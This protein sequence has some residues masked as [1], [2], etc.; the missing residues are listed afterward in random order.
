MQN[1][2]RADRKCEVVLKI[3]V[4]WGK[5]VQEGLRIWEVGVQQ[6]EVEKWEVKGVVGLK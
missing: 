2:P 6:G 4:G 5:K 1:C 3:F